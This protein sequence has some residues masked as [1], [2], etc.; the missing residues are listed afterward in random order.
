MEGEMVL[1]AIM[2]TMVPG[3]VPHPCQLTRQKPNFPQVP[4]GNSYPYTQERELPHLILLTANQDMLF[5]LCSPPISTKCSR[6]AN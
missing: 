5:F 3:A 2:T 6:T 4:E 1:S